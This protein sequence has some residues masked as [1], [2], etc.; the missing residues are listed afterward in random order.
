MRATVSDPFGSYDINA[1]PP[2]TRPTITI[3]DKNGS[4]VVSATA[5]TE[6]GALTTAGTK[7]FEYAYTVPGSPV[8]NW[9]LQVNAVE[10]TEG[11]VSHYR[12]SIMPVYVPQ[13]LISILKSADKAT[14]NP[15]EIIV[16]TVQISNSGTGAGTNVVL[17]DDLSPYGLFRINSYSGAPFF[18]TDT[19][20]P[21][22]SGLTFG[23]PE[24]IHNNNGVWVTTLID[25]GDGAPAG[26]DGT[27]T[28]WRI[29]MGGTIRPGGSFILNYQVIVK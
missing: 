24:Y 15:G 22:P 1:N 14:V 2:T 11:L 21:T 23:V 20:S 7:T 28:N 13:P 25:G 26:Y 17:K 16:Y 29:P 3:K 19:S 6:L 27:V 5:M 8:G 12:Q 18:Y 4:T 10:G 9:L